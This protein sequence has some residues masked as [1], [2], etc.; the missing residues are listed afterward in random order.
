MTTYTLLVAAVEQLHWLPIRQRIDYTLA[1]LT[2][3]IRRS[4]TPAYLARHIRSRCQ[5]SRRLSRSLFLRHVFT[6][7]T[8]YHNSLC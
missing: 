1:V 7:Q 8:Y 3:K 4:S 2:F 6:A 5:I